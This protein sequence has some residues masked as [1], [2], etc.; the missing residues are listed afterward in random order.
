MLEIQRSPTTLQP[1]S[2]TS[3]LLALRHQLSQFPEADIEWH[4]WAPAEFAANARNISE[5]NLGVTSASRPVR[6]PRRN[7]IGEFLDRNICAA[8][9]VIDPSV[10]PRFER[11]DIGVGDVA[12][13]NEIPPL[14]A[15]TVNFEWLVFKLAAKKNTQDKGI[16]ARLRLTRT[17]YVKIP[18]NCYGQVKQAVEHQAI[19]FAG[20]LAKRIEIEKIGRRVLMVRRRAVAIR[21]STTRCR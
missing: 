11:C 17:I 4:L 19:L 21:M 6:L 20:R 2:P 16:R 3:C 1:I 10:A 9:D 8:A 18:Q 12:D 15:G 13:M 7:H 14:R 5:R